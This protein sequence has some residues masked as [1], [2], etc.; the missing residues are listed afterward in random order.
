VIILVGVSI[1]MGMPAEE[2]GDLV[3]LDVGARAK[4]SAV[5][6]TWVG[7]DD[8]EE[9]TQDEDALGE[10]EDALAKM[11]RGRSQ[12]Q[13]IKSRQYPKCIIRHK[14][15]RVL[16]GSCSQSKWFYSRLTNDIQDNKGNCITRIGRRQKGKPQHLRAKRCKDSDSQK[17]RKE[18]GAFSSGKGKGT[19][20]MHT[21]GRKVVM[22]K[23]YGEKSQLWHYKEF[24]RHSRCGR[25]R[26]KV[27][28][29]NG[30]L[31]TT[32]EM[33]NF[34]SM[35]RKHITLSM[36][37]KPRKGTPFSYASKNHVNAF[38]IDLPTNTGKSLGITLWVRNRRIKTNV[39][40]PPSKWTHVAVTWGN[41]KG[42]LKLYIGGKLKFKKSNV[43]RGRKITPGGCVMLGQ[44]A[45]RACKRRIFKAA[46]QG[47]ITD[48]LLWNK[49]LDGKS[50]LKR[51]YLPVSPKVLAKIH[52]L[53]GP[54]PP[55]ALRVAWLSRQY[56]SQELK[57]T[58]PPR[59]TLARQK[60]APKKITGPAGW[61]SWGGT[62]DVHYNNFNGCKY[63]DQSVGDWTA[64]E[65][66]KKYWQAYPLRITYRTSPNRQRCSWCMNGAVSYI[67]G[68]GVQYRGDQA[69]ATFGGFNFPNSRYKPYASFK[70]KKATGGW[71]RSK[72]MRAK[73]T[74][75]S[76]NANLADGTQ[77]NC[78]RVWIGIRVPKKLTGKI[79]GMAGT[80]KAGQWLTGP[81]K[82]AS[83][84]K[85][86]T[87][88][89]GLPGCKPRYQ[90][91]IPSS[92][93]NGNG[94]NK[95]IVKWMKSWQVT[96]PGGPVK[97]ALGYLGPTKP[98]SFNR[99]AGQEIK[100]IKG[101]SK[102]RPSGAKA[103]AKKACRAL[104]NNKKYFAKCLF[105][106][107]VLGPKAVKRSIKDRMA[108]RAAKPFKPTHYDVRD[109]S[110]WRSNAKWVGSPSWGCVDGFAS[111]VTKLHKK[112][113]QAA[114]KAKFMKNNCKCKARYL[115][116]CAY[117]HFICIAHRKLTE[118]KELYASHVYGA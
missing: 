85:P 117:D 43:M 33:K 48:V 75:G 103:K 53:T 12:H 116:E 41:K 25:K 109:A 23:Y 105:D 77:V 28:K 37:M 55:K 64:V 92:P 8:S 65:V 61:M 40:V 101:V 4:E 38:V 14:D 24:V 78:R 54:K 108:K 102:N 115:G 89:P 67:D 57:S 100:P 15:G 11:F 47:R 20:V 50:I 46:Y 70:N 56:G 39:K 35:P 69:S 30:K 93:F 52:K 97:S 110:K 95:P 74:S 94:A 59:C 10:S 7:E 90:Y 2:E 111:M 21:D 114:H 76:F 104:R 62:G 5:R 18:C 45:K 27:M 34:L 83:G 29:F 107:F 49:I 112:H 96:R 63:D 113:G 60:R 22:D 106:Y 17:F 9:T 87:Q 19:R 42:D 51:S 86:W 99:V 6:A 16:L 3:M 36:W 72:Y 66:F 88:A 26:Y 13:P 118:L 82:A 58:F 44:K 31:S 91:P 1:V 81:N 84:L 71:Q 68:C 32:V 73:A 98:G 80:G 79:G